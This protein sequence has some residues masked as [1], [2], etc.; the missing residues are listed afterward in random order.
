KKR[1]DYAQ[2]SGTSNKTG[3]PLEALEKVVVRDGKDAFAGFDGFLFLY[4]G[5]RIQTNRGALYYPHAGT[6]GLQ[7]RRLPYLL[8]AEGGSRQTAVGAFVKELGE[9]LGLPDLAARPE[10]SGSTGLGPWCAMSNPFG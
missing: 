1:A 4:A 5:E 2:G 10:D 3:L 8:N 6:I 7:S 9:V